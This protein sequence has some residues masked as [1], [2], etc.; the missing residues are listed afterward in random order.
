MLISMFEMTKRTLIGNK[1]NAFVHEN[2]LKL[3]SVLVRQ[4]VS[5]GHRQRIDTIEVIDL[6]TGSKL[7]RGVGEVIG[8][9]ANN[10]VST[11]PNWV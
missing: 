6:S 7:S 9:V 8:R 3:H 5:S 11:R 2:L 1:N 10:Q 4:G